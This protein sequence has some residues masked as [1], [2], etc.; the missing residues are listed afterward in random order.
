MRKGLKRFMKEGMDLVED[1]F[2]CPFCGS[3]DT[4]KE[5]CEEDLMEASCYFCDKSYV[6]V[7][8]PVAVHYYDSEAGITHGL[9]RDEDGNVRYYEV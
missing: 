8:K 4:G 3:F 1:R 9:Y 7:V 6:L 5:D 2:R